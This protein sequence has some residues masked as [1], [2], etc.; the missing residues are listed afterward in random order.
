MLGDYMTL[1]YDLERQFQIDKNGCLP[2]IP[3]EQGIA[4]ADPEHFVQGKSCNGVPAPALRTERN[5][6]RSARCV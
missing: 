5:S 1:E 2:L 3:D 6:P 4:R